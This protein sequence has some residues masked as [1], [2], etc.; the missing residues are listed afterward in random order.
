MADTAKEAIAKARKLFRKLRNPQ[1]WEYPE[2]QQYK[3]KLTS[4]N[5]RLLPAG[6]TAAIKLGVWAKGMVNLDIGGGRYN[7]TTEAINSEGATNYTYDPWNRTV[8]ENLSAAEAAE[9]GVDTV[10]IHNTLNVIKEA[11][12]IDRILRQAHA[13]LKAGGKVFITVYVGDGTGIGKETF[14]GESWQRNEKLNAK[15]E[16]LK[17]TRRYFKDA[18]IVNGMIV[19]TKG[20]STKQETVTEGELKKFKL[21]RGGKGYKVGKVIGS[22]IY[23]HKDYEVQFPKAE[24]EAAKK[25]YK[26]ENGDKPYQVVKYNS[27]TGAF[28]F[29]FS[30]DFDSNSEPS[31]N[32]GITIKPDGTSK[33]FGDAGWIYHHKWMFVGDDYKG[34]DTEAEKQRSIEWASLEDVDKARIG[35]R[36][37]WDENVAPRL[38]KAETIQTAKKAPK[39][40]KKEAPSGTRPGFTKFSKSIDKMVAEK[41]LTPDDAVLIKEIFKDTSDDFLL[42]INVE[43]NPYLKKT[44]GRAYEEGRRATVKKGLANLLSPTSSADI[45][46]LVV[47]LHEYGH[48]AEMFLLT[49]AAEKAT[50]KEVFN[51]LKREGRLAHFQTGLSDKLDGTQKGGWYFTKN[52]EEFLVQAF[53]EYLITNKVP[54][55]KLLPLMKKMAKKLMDGIRRLVDRKEHDAIKKLEPLFEKMLSGEGNYAMNSQPVSF[56]EDLKALLGVDEAPDKKAEKKKAPPPPTEPPVSETPQPVTP[57]EKEIVGSAKNELSDQIREAR[58]FNAIE[59]DV[60]QTNE[61][62]MAEAKLLI[63]ED[64]EKHGDPHPG[65][66][67]GLADMIIENLRQGAGID[68]INEAIL[69]MEHIRIQVNMESNVVMVNDTKVSET[70]RLKAR[71]NW[72]ASAKELDR[73]EYAQKLLGTR[74]ARV[75]QFRTRV[76]TS[77]YT[78]T[79]MERA[80]QMENQREKPI[81]QEIMDLGKKSKDNAAAIKAAEEAK[82]TAKE[83]KDLKKANKKILKELEKLTDEY[84][85]I[86]KNAKK[87]AQAV[88]DRDNVTSAVINKEATADAEKLIEEYKKEIIGDISPSVIKWARK[89]VDQLKKN[90]ERKKKRRSE[91]NAKYDKGSIF[92]GKKIES[93]KDSEPEAEETQE[94]IRL[95]ERVELI[96]ILIQEWAAYLADGAMTAVEY[97]SALLKEYGNDIKSF[98]PDIIEKGYMYAAGDFKP[99]REKK[100]KEEKAF[101]A[102]AKSK[103]TKTI[104]ID[105]VVADIKKKINDYEPTTEQPEAD[106]TGLVEKMVKQYIREGITDVNDLAWKVHEALVDSVDGL[107]IDPKTKRP[108]EAMQLIGKYGKRK[109]PSSVQAHKD[110]RNA[111]AEAL[112]L[113]KIH[114]AA[115]QLSVARTGL[116]RDKKT[117]ELRRLERKFNRYMR[118]AAEKGINL[119]VGTKEDH[120]ASTLDALKTRAENQLVDIQYEIDKLNQAIE[121]NEQRKPPKGPEKVEDPDLTELKERVKKKKAELAEVQKAHDQTFKVENIDDGT[122][123]KRAIKLKELQIKIHAQ[124]LADR[125]HRRERKTKDPLPP[126]DILDERKK[127]DQWL[128][129]ELQILRD[130][131]VE[132]RQER[133]AVAVE[134]STANYL[135]KIK[136]NEYVPITKKMVEDN[137]NLADLRKKQQEVIKIFKENQAKDPRFIAANQKKIDDALFEVIMEMFERIQSG[138]V[139]ARKKPLRIKSDAERMRD[140]LATQIRKMQA[141]QKRKTPEQKEKARLASLTKQYEK[142][143]KD[144][145]DEKW[146]AEKREEKEYSPQEQLMRDQIA[147]LHTIKRQK[148]NAALPK[149][150]RQDIQLQAYKTRAEN[151]LAALHL[152]LRTEDF[153]TKPRRKGPDLDAEAL[154]LEKKI[155][156]IEQEIENAKFLK[157]LNNRSLWEKHVWANNSMWKYTSWM[158]GFNF[159]RGLMTGGEMSAFLRQGGF[160][161]LSKPMVTAKGAVPTAFKVLFSK[162][163][164]KE[165]QKEIESRDSYKNMVRDGLFLADAGATLTN[166]EEEFQGR[167]IKKLPLGFGKMM[168]KFQDSYTAFLNRQ[169]ADAYDAMVYA[170]SKPEA[171]VPMSADGGAVIA[172]FVNIATGR[173]DLGKA[174]NISEGLALAFFSPRYVTSRFQL[175]GGLVYHPTRGIVSAV[176]AKMGSKV[177]ENK[178]MAKIR[179][180]ISGE[181]ARAMLGGYAVLKI[182]SMMLDMGEEEEDEGLEGW[183]KL[184]YWMSIS[185]KI[186]T[187]PTSSQF[188][189]LNFGNTHIDPFF[190]LLQTT[191]LLS[192]LR[193]SQ[194]KSSSGEI[195]DLSGE[196]KAYGMGVGDVLHRF[197]RSKLSPLGSTV[198]NFLIYREDFMGDPV[199]LRHEVEGYG[200]FFSESLAGVKSVGSGDLDQ[201]KKDLENAWAAHQSTQMGQLT[202]PITWGDIGD[203]YQEHNIPKATALS[204][205]AFFG[206]GVNVYDPEARKK[207]NKGRTA[208][209][210]AGALKAL[211]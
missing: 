57:P 76:V 147:A 16:Y 11:E 187:D 202:F 83:I 195:K 92:S 125:K 160:L 157:A 96:S 114:R 186:E 191:V 50:I 99:K 75:L 142:L 86:T 41:T 119:K 116:Q 174:N 74:V 211:E 27:K 173:G 122:Q 45:N 24:L 154:E 185:K 84:A 134:K 132:Y 164:F 196:D 156:I 39:K 55:G 82:A 71:R 166:L 5:A 13:A 190:G 37:F 148:R 168:V 40:K 65:R 151:K 124:M 149:K 33:K 127:T 17:T 111:R 161:F 171:A 29:I 201:A 22:N 206:A 25:V 12:V 137:P 19:A 1:D 49:S 20:V 177:S 165:T 199:N 42:S 80:D 158:E 72:D 172:S 179:G 126:S 192:R 30:S 180:Q 62:T 105:D 102:V 79:A 123:L 18:K 140:L 93:E 118:E 56:R 8:E 108:V 104:S 58:G 36:K 208:L 204:M 9:A 200:K 194:I 101:A 43:S 54:D 121:K 15:S 91:I 32:G 110:Y 7:N 135:K 138:D 120:I 107:S 136:N 153:E 70:D 145:R 85:E 34:F 117:D 10:T 146:D 98:I 182:A 210:A 144:I 59:S 38:K 106:I 51:E 141:E 26:E 109:K 167:L 162:D 89:R 178:E 97:E 131:D 88:I 113:A 130:L 73:I 184:M 115:N 170:Y 150:T 205:V 67:S 198:S 3:S 95:K 78:L 61:E 66:L 46:S 31:I 188:L 35:Q 207:K 14:G 64:R 60:E 143:K 197:Y 90:A 21:K 203:N 128:K 112:L 189:K 52:P 139:G 23:V 159:F 87:H 181:Y 175:L 209:K 77:K 48:L 4:I 176:G 133:D 155:L 129:E 193:Y 103:K 152:Q 94:S 47:F 183:D 163:G 44:T 2:N 6:I 63:R 81:S 53:A 100:T 69:V 28:S 169:R 68:V